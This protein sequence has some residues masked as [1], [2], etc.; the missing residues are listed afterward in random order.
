MEAALSRAREKHGLPALLSFFIPG[1]GQLIKGDIFGGLAVMAGMIVGGLLCFVMI[2]FVVLPIV[3]IL[4][5]YDAYSAPDA[6]TKRELKRL[7]KR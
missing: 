3:W 4:Q 6:A 1:L 2:G 7:A 5:L